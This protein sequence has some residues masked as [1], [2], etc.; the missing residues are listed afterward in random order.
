MRGFVIDHPERLSGSWEVKG[1]HAIYGLHIQLTTKVNGAPTTLIGAQQI[2]HSALIEVYERTGPTRK[3]GDGSWFSDELPQLLWTD[4]HLVIKESAA[5]TGP[6]VQL[7]LIFDPVSTS[8]SG[9]FRR[10]T[11]DRPV[12]SFAL[13]RKLELPEAHL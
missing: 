12:T 9:R 10:G 5:K 11:V 4:R 6:K 8:W 13:I 1:D 7:D 3:V 2:F